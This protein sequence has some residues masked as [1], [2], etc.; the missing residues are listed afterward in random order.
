MPIRVP[1]N[2]PA[3]ETLNAEQV[4]VMPQEMAAQ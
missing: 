3:L 1:N 2:L 4:D